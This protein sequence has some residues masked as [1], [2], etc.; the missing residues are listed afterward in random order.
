M[1]PDGD[2]AG[3]RDLSRRAH[4]QGHERDDGLRRPSPSWRTSWR[5][6]SIACADAELAVDRSVMDALFAA[7]ERARAVRWRSKWRAARRAGRRR[8]CASRAF[9]E[10][11]IS[12]EPSTT[13]TQALAIPQ[14]DAASSRFRPP[15]RNSQIRA[16][17][18]QEFAI[19]TSTQ[20]VR[21]SWCG[22]TGR[23][24]ADRARSGSS[25]GAS[26]GLMN[27]IGELVIARGR[28]THIAH[29]SAI[30]RS[31][32][33]VAQTS[34]LIT[35]LRDEITASRMVPVWQVFDRFPRSRARRG[36]RG[37]QGGRVRRRGKD[38]ELDR[39]MLD[40]IGDPIVHLL[41]NAIDH[42]I[43]TPERSASRRGS[44]RAGR[45]D[46]ERR[47]RPVGDRRSR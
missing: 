45:L 23:T 39:S 7:V 1:R 26:N 13:F 38:I 9:A 36:A 47:A 34:R 5:R 15:P 18:T 16:A 22:A 33:T 31:M 12:R 6:C 46:A 10:L 44:R 20:D 2:G 29:E 19:P 28:L 21:D 14:R 40:E 30:R 25:F 32:E 17:A 43:E 24:R 3:E 41:R 11:C 27:L 4:D 35:E 8:A 42:G 37:R